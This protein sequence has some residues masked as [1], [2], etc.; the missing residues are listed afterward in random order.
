MIQARGKYSW[1]SNNIIT[2]AEDG[3][4]E[5]EWGVCNMLSNQ[6]Q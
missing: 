1:I 5:K 2:F 6:A 3:R 4:K